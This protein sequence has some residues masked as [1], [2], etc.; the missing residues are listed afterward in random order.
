ME[1][2]KIDSMILWLFANFLAVHL[3]S[4]AG[5]DAMQCLVELVGTVS[6]CN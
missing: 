5:W 4:L 3:D 6:D 2:A 1:I